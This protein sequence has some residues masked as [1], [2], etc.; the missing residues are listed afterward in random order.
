LDWQRRF[1]H[2][3]RQQKIGNRKAQM[4]AV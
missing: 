1:E 4:T 3:K 2:M